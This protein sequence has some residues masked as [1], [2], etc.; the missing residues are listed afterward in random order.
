MHVGAPPGGETGVKSVTCL[1][2]EA[3]WKAGDE[4]RWS[5][6]LLDA[7]I[8]CNPSRNVGP[9]RENVTAPQA[10]LVEYRDGTRGAVLNL[11]EQ[12]ADFS[13]AVTVRG[14]EQPIATHF[15]LP[16]PPGAK[17]FDP[18]TFNIEK[19]LAAGAP[20]YPVERTLLTSTMLDLALRSQHDGGKPVSSPALD[21]R[22]TPPASSG[23]F[24]G[25]V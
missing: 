8:A 16:P 20:P 11:I 23:F 22:Y 24:R 5:T 14:S 19:F 21:I 15:Y 7:A 3:V 18:L 9:V 12:V 2:G 10:I 17:F 4:G 6:K 13:F 1:R 25:P